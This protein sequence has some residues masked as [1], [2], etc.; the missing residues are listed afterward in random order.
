MTFTIK[1]Y[2]QEAIEVQISSL[3]GK[4]DVNYAGVVKA[5]KKHRSTTE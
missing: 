5:R 4:G 2:E 1:T 3:K